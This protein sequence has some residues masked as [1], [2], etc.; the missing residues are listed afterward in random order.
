MPNDVHILIQVYVNYI[1]NYMY[2]QYI[3]MQIQ[4]P[5]VKSSLIFRALLVQKCSTQKTKSVAAMTSA[6]TWCSHI[7]L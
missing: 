7:K 5:N 6:S 2:E 4:L 3:A 1:V